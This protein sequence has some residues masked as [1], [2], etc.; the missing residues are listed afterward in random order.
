MAVKSRI[1]ILAAVLASVLPV[2]AFD[3]HDWQLWTTEGVD[4]KVT[5]QWNARLETEFYWGDGMTDLFYRHVDLGVSR[6]V[7]PW[8]G[9]G[10]NHR[11]VEQEKNGEWKH[12]NRPS[13]TGTFYWNMGAL[14]LSDRNRFESRLRE[15]ADDCARYRNRLRVSL[16]R[17]WLGV[18][19]EPYVSDEFF[20]D[21]EQQEINENRA[22]AGCASTFHKRFKLDLYYML[23]SGKKDDRWIDANIVGSS[24]SVSF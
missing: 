5:D 4:Y 16:P 7:V 1:V 20:I 14:R 21:S 23:Q 11:Y 6:K 19:V 2:R 3:N 15:D 9:I 8:F 24:V 10:M 17:E 22:S 18:A 12:E 13:V